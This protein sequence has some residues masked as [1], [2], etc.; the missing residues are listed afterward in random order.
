VSGW[1]DPLRAALDTAPSPVTVFVRDDDAGWEDARLL[2]L[3]DLF[4]AHEAPIDLAVIPTELH[5][6]LAD[7][8]L[9][10]HADRAG[11]VGLHQHGYCHANHQAD[12]RKCEFGAARSFASQYEDI[13]EGQ[14]ILEEQLGDVLDPIFTPPWNRCT[15]STG[16]V[17]VELGIEVLS[18]DST[19]EPLAVAG[20]DELVVQVDWFAARKGARLSR[21]QLGALLAERA[22]GPAPLGVMLHHAVMDT[23]EFDGVD[24][25][26]GVL[27][28]TPNVA[29]RSMADVAH[30]MKPTKGRMR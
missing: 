20:L 18:R 26:L 13:T 16:A 12:G 9:Q 19:A 22:A 3:L 1:L 28:G 30:T 8:L 25:L 4:A 14:R 2:A 5:P 15:A 11:R 23:A 27:T 17:L 10:V 24:E 21:P 7:D 29:M 6:K